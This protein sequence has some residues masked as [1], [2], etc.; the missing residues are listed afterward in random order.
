MRDVFKLGAYLLI[1]A[2]IAGIGVASVNSAT[3]PIIADRAVAAKEDGLLEV[4]P[5]AE[6]VENETEKYVEESTPGEIVEVNVAYKGSE[7]VGVIY[8]VEPNGYDGPVSTMVGFDIEKK[9]ITRIKILSQSETPGLGA[10]CTEP[11]FTD[12]FQGKDASQPL[13]V[14]KMELPGENEI[15]AITAST[16]TT[17]AVTDGVNL[18][19]EH[20]IEY[21]N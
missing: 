5:G 1:I 7:T 16:V 13:T 19:R 11:E 14:T 9:E 10:L 6:V 8:I 3:A 17:D 18:V 4:Y 20:F 21:F 15:V 2:S 12:R